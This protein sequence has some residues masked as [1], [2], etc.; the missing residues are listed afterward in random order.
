VA[1]AIHRKIGTPK[2]IEMA[3]ALQREVGPTG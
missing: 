3:K 1:I 2:D